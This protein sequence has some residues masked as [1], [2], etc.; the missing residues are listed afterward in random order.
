[1][2]PKTKQQLFLDC[3]GVLADFDALA[4]EILGMHPR[5]YE[6][7]YGSGRFWTRL[8]QHGSFYRDLPLM[9]DARELFDSVAHL[10]PVILTGCPMGGWAEAQKMAWAKKHFPGTRMITCASRDKSRYMR[11]RDVLV[12]DYLKYKHLWEQAGGVFVHHKSA[13][14]SL[15]SLQE[16]GI[17]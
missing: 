10:N 4:G 1:M 15:A 16:H 13:K 12:D 3:D 11:P 8:R 9:A 5:V 2:T 7:R 14:E 17:L 6:E